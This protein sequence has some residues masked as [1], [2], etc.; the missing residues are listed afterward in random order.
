MLFS[1]FLKDGELFKGCF[2]GRDFWKQKIYISLHSSYNMAKKTLE[3]KYLR[4][5]PE[6]DPSG[7]QGMELADQIIDKY[8][9][10]ENFPK[11]IIKENK[12]N[13]F[14]DKEK[15]G[16]LEKKVLFVKR[17]DE[18]QLNP[19]RVFDNRSEKEKLIKEYKGDKS[20]FSN[21]SDYQIG[22]FFKNLY[23]SAKVKSKN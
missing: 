23:N 1:Y 10:I 22:M 4:Y 6:E 11:L 7:A 12:E 14:S 15:G 18:M 5:N 17:V 8:G 13:K 2:K 19:E 3:E 9:S 16:D 21:F 20:Y